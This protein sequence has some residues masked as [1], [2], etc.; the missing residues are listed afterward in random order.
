MAAPSVSAAD[1]LRL[2]ATVGVALLAT[3]PSAASITGA[4]NTH[5]VRAMWPIAA[6]LW[7][8]VGWSVLES[9]VAARP[10]LRRPLGRPAL[11]TAAP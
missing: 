1:E 10:A 8:A 3:V 5:W 2:Q 4:L 9:I 11:A 7:I 6:A